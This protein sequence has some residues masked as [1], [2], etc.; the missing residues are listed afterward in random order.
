MEDRPNHNGVLVGRA[1]WTHC[2]CDT[3][4]SA[5]VSLEID[6]QGALLGEAMVLG[7]TT[8]ARVGTVVASGDTID[9]EV[10]DA[11]IAGKF[12]RGW[13]IAFSGHDCIDQPGVGL[14]H[15]LSWRL[16]DPL[17]MLG[18]FSTTRDGS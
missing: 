18:T 17:R 16:G 15:D 5:R 3:T 1:Q 13:Q 12:G 9:H 4:S 7:P 11:I 8:I 14:A 10:E 2:I 6:E